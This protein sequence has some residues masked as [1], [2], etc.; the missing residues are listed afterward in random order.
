MLICR[1]RHTLH[2]NIYRHHHLNDQV[3]GREG[4][5][6]CCFIS[7]KPFVMAGLDSGLVKLYLCIVVKI[8]IIVLVIVIVIVISKEFYGFRFQLISLFPF[9]LWQSRRHLLT[10]FSK[11]V[12]FTIIV[13]LVV[14]MMTTL[15]YVKYEWC[16][17]LFKNN[18]VDSRQGCISCGILLSGTGAR[19]VS[20]E[21]MENMEMFSCSPT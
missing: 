20:S 21:H 9:Q 18:T 2:H 12:V 13:F 8:N 7:S 14:V 10:S 4:N 1:D 5:H 11:V 16:H 19:G 15:V 3:M 17:V 6:R